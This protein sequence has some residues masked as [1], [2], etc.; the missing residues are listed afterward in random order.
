MCV[1][2]KLQT[3]RCHLKYDWVRRVNGSMDMTVGVM[4]ILNNFCSNINCFYVGLVKTAK[5]FA[6]T[7]LLTS[8]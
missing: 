6:V 1:I 5:A 8:V 2:C 7:L 4:L 3:T